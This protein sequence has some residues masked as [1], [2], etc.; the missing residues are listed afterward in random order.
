MQKLILFPLPA[1]RLMS[2][3]DSG[4][5]YGATWSYERHP[6]KYAFYHS[7]Q[8]NGRPEY[9]ASET[10]RQPVLHYDWPNPRVLAKIGFS[11]RY[12]CPEWNGKDAPNACYKQSPRA[13]QVV[14]S[15]R[16]HMGWTTLLDVRDAGFTTAN[17]FRAW[18][19]PKKNRQP[20]SRIGIRFKTSIGPHTVSVTNVKM[21][22]EVML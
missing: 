12:P 15:N 14:G 13:F 6:P 1:M 8:S 17:Q 19:I 11:N 10:K 4:T 20:F 21:W 16:D 22:E 5:P 3:A 7:W 18:I 9:W 2:Y